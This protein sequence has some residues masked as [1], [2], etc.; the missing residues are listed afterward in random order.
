MKQNKPLPNLFDTTTDTEPVTKPP[1]VPVK[2]EGLKELSIRL[3]DEA[4]KERK[5]NEQT[6]KS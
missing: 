2:R 6:E 1:V 4:I 3:R 5:Q